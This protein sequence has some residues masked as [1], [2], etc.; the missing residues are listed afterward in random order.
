MSVLRRPRRAAVLALSS[1]VVAGLVVAG[2]APAADRSHRELSRAAPPAFLVA[3]SARGASLPQPRTV[4][5]PSSLV[6]LRTALLP[7]RAQGQEIAFDL[8]RQTVTGRFTRIEHNAAYTAWSGTLDVDLGTFT[9]VRSGSVYRAAFTWPQGLW[10]VTPAAG[11]RY[12]LTEV[13]PYAGPGGDDVVTFPAPRVRER[14][15]PASDDTP[16]RRRKSRIDVLFG[17]TKAALAAAGSKAALKAA[18]GQ[19]AATTNVAFANSGIKARI[20]VKGVVK[21]RGHESRSPVRDLR[22]LQRPHDGTFD[23]AL[24]ARARHHADIVHLITQGSS[25]Q[26][27]GVGALPRTVR[28]A[29]PALGISTSYLSCLPYLVVTHE[30]GHNLG[31]DHID[32]PGVTHYS[33]IAGSYGWYDVA[34]HF[35]TAMGYYN[36]CEDVGDYTCVRIPWYSNPHGSFYGQPIGSRRANNARVISM[37]APRVARYAH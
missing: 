25:A 20:R 37:L 19:A 13:T 33:K 18:V 8:G 30:L 12:W 36:P 29:R 15:A 11:S 3:T 26:M 16:R 2:P 6:T 34:H 7:R 1:A 35:L 23:G 28:E 4:T 22:R 32:Y 9:I 14:P 27:C 24:R 17:Y 10:A 5:G 21:V 31:A